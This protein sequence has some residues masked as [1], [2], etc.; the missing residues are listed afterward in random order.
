MV[1]TA[2]DWWLDH[3]GEVP[4]ED[5]VDGLADLIL[6][7]LPAAAPPDRVLELFRE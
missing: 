6:G 3:A 1:Q 4:R 7:G 2:G 5:V